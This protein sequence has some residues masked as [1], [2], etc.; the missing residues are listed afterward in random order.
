[1]GYILQT[2]SFFSHVARI[3]TRIL[4]TKKQLWLQWWAHFPK[5]LVSRPNIDR[6]HT[7]IATSWAQTRPKIF[8]K[9]IQTL[10]K[11]NPGSQSPPFHPK[12]NQFR[13]PNS[14]QDALKP[15]PGR[16]KH[17]PKVLSIVI[18]VQIWE[19]VWKRIRKQICN[20]IWKEKRLYSGWKL[21]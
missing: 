4:T 8:P 18:W 21:L 20:P 9:S 5:N 16:P 15:L 1:M 19:R 12:I 10:P 7:R 14:P 6:T 11:T 17:V 13:C 2:K 3:L